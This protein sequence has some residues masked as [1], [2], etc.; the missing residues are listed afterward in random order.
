M[1]MTIKDRQEVVDLLKA[2][3]GRIQNSVLWEQQET[4]DRVEKLKKAIERE[5]SIIV[6]MKSKPDFV[7]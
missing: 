4:K 5:E 1:P 7:D 6:A 2:Y 3:V